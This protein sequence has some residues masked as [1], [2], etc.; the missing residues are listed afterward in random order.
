MAYMSATPEHKH[1]WMLRQL[2][3]SLLFPIYYNYLPGTILAKS[4]PGEI[5]FAR[6][7]M[8]DPV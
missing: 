2:Q 6:D 1:K 7:A 5:P 3:R 4:P 8:P